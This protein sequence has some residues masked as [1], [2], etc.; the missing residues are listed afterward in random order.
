MF[1]R[2]FL[3]GIGAYWQ[4]NRIIMKHRLWPYFILPGLI[5]M[6]FVLTLLSLGVFY[7]DDFSAYIQQNWLPEFL[8]NQVMFF[9]TAILI[10]L[11][12]LLIGYMTYKHI[13]LILFAPFLG[14]LSEIVD[15]L[16][17]EKEPPSFNWR[18]LVRDI[19][20]GLRLNVRNIGWTIFFSLGAWLLIF[21]P[22]VGFVLSPLFLF[23]IQAYY[24]GF[25]L[26]DLTLER[27]RLSAKDSI[28]FVKTHR[29]FAMGIGTGFILILLIPVIG[30]FA[31][32]AY[33]IVAATLATLERIE[34][35]AQH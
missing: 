6:C 4:A 2:E 1:I 13:V 21:I 28:H 24:G 12:A 34:T 15:K 35:A 10:W 8:N 30:W 29:S 16:I 14:M 19:L 18:Q 7:F 17:T 32:P 11:L 20:R 22:V 31:A 9:V 27:R 3:A 25:G 23:L 5:S 33:G 26:I